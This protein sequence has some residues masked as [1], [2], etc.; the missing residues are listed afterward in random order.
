MPLL[1]ADVGHV[2][3]EEGTQFPEPTPPATP[4]VEAQ[5][6][7][8]AEEAQ[9]KA[10]DEKEKEEKKKRQRRRALTTTAWISFANDDPEE[11]FDYCGQM[12]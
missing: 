9:K 3:S 12:V 6:A 4:D 10:K 2:T 8:Q 11:R 5:T 7:Q 1:R